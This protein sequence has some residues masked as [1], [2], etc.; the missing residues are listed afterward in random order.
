MAE[1]TGVNKPYIN[2]QVGAYTSL[3]YYIKGEGV[4]QIRIPPIILGMTSLMTIT[5][6][7][8]G[9]VTFN[10]V[11]FGRDF[12]TAKNECGIRLNSHL[13]FLLYA[14]EQTKI[15]FEMSALMGY[16][17]CICNPIRTS[18]GV[19]MCY[20][21][22]KKYLSPDGTLENR[23]SLSGAE[24]NAKTYAEIQ[25]YSVMPYKTM[26]DIWGGQPVPT[27][28]EFL[29]VCAKNS[30]R[31]V[32]SVH[33]DIDSAGWQVI[34]KKLLKYNLLNSV[35]VKLFAP[36]VFPTA[37]GVLGNDIESYIIIDYL[38]TE[39]AAETL[40][41]RLTSSPFTN[42][43][44]RLGVE[45]G[46]TAANTEAIIGTFVDAGLYVTA[47]AYSPGDTDYYETLMSYGVC[48]FTDD[49]LPNTSLN[50]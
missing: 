49:A 40:A 48:E 7:S 23:I 5:V 21:E 13:G 16:K 46:D 10:Y 34:R 1:Y 17:A 38:T 2:I 3:K 31:P 20:H 26:S 4:Q 14:P 12:H 28:D 43:T 33:P 9:T 35:S 37:F 6:P 24:F 30:M 39:E 15:S 42:V 36:E 19:W 18:D 41:T 25:E 22:N 27:L 11:D 45:L 29:E 44:C 8:G 50:W 47:Q 32:F